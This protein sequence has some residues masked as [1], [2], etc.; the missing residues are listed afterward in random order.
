MKKLLIGLLSGV[1]ALSCCACGKPAT[2]QND[3]DAQGRLI[4]DV[5]APDQYAGSEVNKQF[6]SWINALNERPEIKELNVVLQFQAMVQLPASLNQACITGKQPDIVV[7]D[8]F[9]TPSNTQ[10][11]V[12]LDE[13]IEADGIDTSKFLPEAYNELTVDGKQYGLPMDADPWG[14]YVNMDIV[15]DYNA[16]AADADKIDID[17]LDTWSELKTV[18]DKLTIR[19]GTTVKRSGLNTTSADGQFFSFV[20]TGT[21]DLINTDK[22]SPTYGDTVMAE[23]TVDQIRADGKSTR[24]YDTLKYFEELYKLN[25]S[26]NGQ[27]GTDAFG[28]GYCAMTYGSIYFPQELSNYALKNYKM[29]PYPARDLTYLPKGNLDPAATDA[30]G[31]RN[32]Q[33][34][35]MLGGY[36]L[37]I[38]QPTNPA[39]R[40][41]AWQERADKAWEVIKLWMTNDEINKEYFTTNKAI[42]CRQD[43]WN[44]EFYAQDGVMKDIIPYLEHYKMRPSIV[45]YETFEA[46]IVRSKI[47]ELKEGSKTGLETY[48]GIRDEGNKSLR[49]SQG[50]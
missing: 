46:S 30:H 18:A 22:N 44:N 5:W 49:L 28:N 45:G 21:G 34:G 10:V 50:R 7:W 32:G 29:I 15:N 43:L 13:R 19:E 25:L 42:T 16:K 37:A 41:A 47:Q 1:V 17:A 6:T 8:R 27:G 48:N 35:G 3:Y 2:G 14:L 40:N 31:M 20:Y 36:G 11:L 9:A 23:G 33:V 39:M 4:L 38:A 24:I 26:D 12:P